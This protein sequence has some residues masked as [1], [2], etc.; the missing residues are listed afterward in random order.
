MKQYF[1]VIIGGGFSGLCLA[2]MLTNNSFGNKPIALLE[3]NKRVG[4]KILST[5]NGQG[6][7]TNA[8]LSAERYHGDRT[9]ACEVLKRYDNASLLNFFSRLGLMY[10]ERDNKYYPASFFAGAVCDVLRF[11]LEEKNIE[12][13]T[14]HCVTDITKNNNGIFCVRCANGEEFFALNVITAF[15][16]SSGDGFYTDGSSYSLVKTFGH[17]VTKLSP[18][19][20]QL[21]T[22][23]EKIKGLKGLKTEAQVKLCDQN[24]QLCS[25]S[26]DLLFTDFGVSGNTVFSA[27]AYLSECKTPV[28]HIEFLPKVTQADLTRLLLQKNKSKMTCSRLLVSVLPSRLA[29]CV[30]S[31]ANVDPES[32]ADEKCILKIV[33]AIKDYSLT[34]L[35]TAGFKSSQVTSGGV[36][37]REIDV[38][39]MQSK[40]CSGLY[41]IGEALNVDGDCG[42]YNLQ[43][44]YSSAAVCAEALNEKN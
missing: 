30:C 41:V 34:V 12:I 35:G 33:K 23:R 27:S 38:N 8:C 4:K 28:L 19:L 6:N 14:E 17:T 10:C 3:A 37:T 16:G 24:K 1:A 9:F 42:G 44:A 43:W 26:G 2:S 40:L 36:N 21:K 11:S 5:G 18:S 25:F 20:V 39:T 22:Q 13:F 32:Y 7:I 29:L 31:A 15:G